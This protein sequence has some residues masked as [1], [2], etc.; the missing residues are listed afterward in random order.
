MVLL[1]GTYRASRGFNLGIMINEANT[2]DLIDQPMSINEKRRTWRTATFHCKCDN[3]AIGFQNFRV[4][5]FCKS[6]SYLIFN[7]QVSHITFCPSC[8]M[9]ES[10]QIIGH[11]C[12]ACQFATIIY[13]KSFSLQI[14][15]TA[16]YVA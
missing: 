9:N 4:R 12:L 6:C 7:Q 1:L 11:P 10:W 16:K 13:K 8:N 5:T 14:Q 2:S 3:D 15:S